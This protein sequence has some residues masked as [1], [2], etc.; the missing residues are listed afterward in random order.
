MT[1]WEVSELAK[2]KNWSTNAIRGQ[3]AFNK[4]VDYYGNRNGVLDPE[5]W[6][7]R[8]LTVFKAWMSQF[9]NKLITDSHNTGL[10]VDVE[11]TR[12]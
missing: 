7:G 3:I 1:F 8:G 9:L 6:H 12:E 4:F 5:D 11:I 10:G 2:Q